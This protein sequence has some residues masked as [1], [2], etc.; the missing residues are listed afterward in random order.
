MVIHNM[1]TTVP[2]QE[3]LE[4]VHAMSEDVWNGRNYDRI[5]ELVAE[6]FHQHGPV[7]GMELA[8]R[9]QLKEHIQQ[10]HEA[11]SD[12]ESTVNFVFCDDASEYVCAHLTNTGTHDGVLM[13]IPASGVEGT[14]DVI[15]IYR[16]ADGHIAESWVLGDMYGLF[17]QLGTYPESSHFA[18]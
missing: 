18:A 14:V 4:L 9:S 15:G 8:G 12:L 3:S 6:D 1:A 16:I 7:T 10:Y 13:D 11:F 5:D 17:E 2:N